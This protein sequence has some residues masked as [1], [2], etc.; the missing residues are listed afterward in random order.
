MISRLMTNP[1]DS[2]SD[3]RLSILDKRRI[4]E[5]ITSEKQG[6]ETRNKVNLKW[7]DTEAVH[8]RA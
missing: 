5:E 8:Q 7:N 1:A 3:S 6:E 2:A 4:K